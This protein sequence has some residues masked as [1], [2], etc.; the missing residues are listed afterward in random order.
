MSLTKTS[1]KFQSELGKT[2]PDNEGQLN[3]VIFSE[4]IAAALHRQYGETHAAI[5]SV[6]A[7]T[8]ANE[9]AVKNWFDGKNAPRG[10][11]LI[12]LI[13]HSDCVLEM[14]LLAAG[15]FEILS[16]K[17]FADARAVLVQMLQLI[18]ELPGAAP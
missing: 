8:R 15:R 14:V 9:R 17:K 7:V 12:A 16:A 1:R 4:A 6:V 2:F 11:H 10:H 13:R 5:K 3:S 18:D